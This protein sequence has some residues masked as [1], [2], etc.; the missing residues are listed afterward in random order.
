MS[1]I[2]TPQEA[3]SLSR[4]IGKVSDD[5]ILSFIVEVEQTMIRKTLGDDLYIRIID[6]LDRPESEIKML[7]EGGRYKDR[8]GRTKILTGLKSAEAYYVYAQNVR[9]G[10]YESTRYGMVIKDDSY[11]TGIS[12]KERDMIANNATLIGDTYLKECI[13]YCKDVGLMKCHA[14]GGN[15]HLTTGCIIRKI[16]SV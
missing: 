6:N 11:S 5:K 9:A 1:T 4:P 13:E 14:R 12:Q 15:A 10:D 2:I 16:K 8:C 3:R 7:L